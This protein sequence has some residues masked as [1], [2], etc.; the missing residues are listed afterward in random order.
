MNP[1]E[2]PNVQSI[3]SDTEIDYM[4]KIDLEALIHLYNFFTDYPL[5]PKKQTLVIKMFS[6]EKAYTKKLENYCKR[7]EDNDLYASLKELYDLYYYIVKE[8][9]HERSDKEIK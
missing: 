9:N 2:V 3:M 5:T 1:K 6:K 7:Y 8:E 4:F